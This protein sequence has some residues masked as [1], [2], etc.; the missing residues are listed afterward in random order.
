MTLILLGMLSLLFSNLSYAEKS[1]LPQRHAIV[2]G[3]HTQIDNKIWQEKRVG[4]GVNSLLK[5]ILFDKTPFTFVDDT[6]LLNKQPSEQWM[7]NDTEFK[8]KAL[9]NFAQTYQVNDI[10]WVK[11]LAYKENIITWRLAIFNGREYEDTLELEVCHYQHKHSINCQ[12]GK[13]SQTRELTAVL[14]HPKDD[15]NFNDSGVGQLT[16]KAIEQAVKKFQFYE[17]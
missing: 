7:L 13:S 15:L 5:Q 6:L 8:P 14:Y 16:E 4:F 12:Q 9:E 10:F 1:N 17:K 3:Y 11:I 2:L